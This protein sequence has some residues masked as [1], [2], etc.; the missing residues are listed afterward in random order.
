MFFNLFLFVFNLINTNVSGVFLDD[1]VSNINFVNKDVVYYEEENIT[2][3]DYYN[4]FRINRESVGVSVTAE[5]GIVMDYETG[6][7]LWKKN[8]EE[9]RSIAS[10]T[11]VMTSLVFFDINPYLVGDVVI[12]YGDLDTGS[13]LKL[14]VGDKVSVYDLFYS[15]YI[16]SKND[17]INALVRSTGLSKEEFIEKMNEKAEELGL[18]D[19][20]FTNVNGLDSGNKSTVSDLSLLIKTAYQNKHINKASTMYEY[21]FTGSSG[22]NYVSKNTDKLLGNQFF[23]ILSGKTGYISEAGHCLTI[24]AE[25]NNR[26]FVSVILGSDSEENRFQ[27]TKSVLWWVINNWRFQ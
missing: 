18:L 13:A 19:T 23:D 2:N 5:S 3:E 9:V 8:I 6:K 11:K 25:K 10:I 26:K 27:D 22:K 15:G 20:V 16:G 24:I 12:Q 21:N 4:I 7:I 17:A 1:F 14:E